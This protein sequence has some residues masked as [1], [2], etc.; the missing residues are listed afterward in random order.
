FF[1]SGRNAGSWMRDGTKVA[2]VTPPS[3]SAAATRYGVLWSAVSRVEGFHFSSSPAVRRTASPSVA[4]CTES[5]CAPPSCRRS[6]STSPI[7][8]WVC[9]TDGD[10]LK[11][12]DVIRHGSPPPPAAQP[13]PLRSFH[14]QVL[15]EPVASLERMARSGHA[16]RGQL[17]R[18]HPRAVC[19]G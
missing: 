15:P 9:T 7:G 8:P 6:S 14:R 4:T 17:R 1:M 13:L 16:L 10:A 3:W 5:I 12:V 19:G 2:G 18:E 11:L